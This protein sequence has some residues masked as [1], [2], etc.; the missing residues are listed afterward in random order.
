MK[1]KSSKPK[2]PFDHK[3]LALNGILRDKLKDEHTKS[4]LRD[5]EYI[6]NSPAFLKAIAD[7][8]KRLGFTKNYKISD[9]YDSTDF[10]VGFLHFKEHPEVEMTDKDFMTHRKHFVDEVVKTVNQA[11]LSSSWA[12]YVQ[13]YLA[14]NKPPKEKWMSIPKTIEVTG[15]KKI[16]E[17]Q[18]ELTITLRSGLRYEDYRKAWNAF[19]GTLGEGKRLQKSFSDDETTLRMVADHESGM[20]YKEITAKYFPNNDPVF[21]VDRVKKSIQRAKKRYERDT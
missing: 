16:S 7:G 19:K 18:K 12:L 8:R 21:N 13:E 11:K 10:A 2:L 5:E 4:V 20:S 15:Y 17:N 1:D 9:E 14:F 6:I 3:L